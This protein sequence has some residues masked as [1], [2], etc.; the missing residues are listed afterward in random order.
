[1]SAWLVDSHAL[2]WFLGGDS[3]LSDSARE[4]MESAANEMLVSAASVWE[5]AIKASLGNLVVPGPIPDL[6]ADNGFESLAVTAAHAWAIFDLPVT[7]HK[8]PFDR[9]LVAQAI[10][11]RL[12]IISG[13]KQLDQYAV[14]R[15]W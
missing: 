5:L 4:T 14:Q 6:M 15:H 9:Q 7:D 10:C 2:I 12:P 11:E 13:D 1:M 8:D 3:K